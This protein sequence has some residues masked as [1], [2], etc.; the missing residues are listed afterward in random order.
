MRGVVNK[1]KQEG[2][3]WLNI[4]HLSAIM[5]EL[6]A[7][8]PRLLTVKGLYPSSCHLAVFF[9]EHNQ[10]DFKRTGPFKKA[11][12]IFRREEEGTAR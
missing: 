9:D 2:K 11:S 1:N 8:I 6:S 10:D 12:L 3:Q 4:N 7:E 5:Y